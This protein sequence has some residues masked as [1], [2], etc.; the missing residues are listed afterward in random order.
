MLGYK[1]LF[2]KVKAE[3]VSGGLVA[4][5]RAVLVDIMVIMG[6][7]VMPGVKWKSIL[8]CEQMCRRLKLPRTLSVK[9][10]LKLP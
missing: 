7:Q 1:L 4:E 3:L 6:R 2:D 10:R 9:K 5:T 8:I